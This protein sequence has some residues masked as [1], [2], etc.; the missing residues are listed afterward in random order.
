[1]PLRCFRAVRSHLAPLPKAT[2]RNIVSPSRLWSPSP[3]PISSMINRTRPDTNIDGEDVKRFDNVVR[4]VV[5]GNPTTQLGGGQPQLASGVDPHGVDPEQAG[6]L[7]EGGARAVGCDLL[8]G[9]AVRVRA[10]DVAARVD[11]RA[12]RRRRQRERLH[13]LPDHR[14]GVQR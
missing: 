11:C 13:V 10:V 8:D 2:V 12:A 6:V 9:Q 7:D 14:V 1:M 4:P 5:E 3:I